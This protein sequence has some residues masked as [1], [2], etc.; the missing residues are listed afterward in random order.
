MIHSPPMKNAV[1][2]ERRYGLTRRLTRWGYDVTLNLPR[3]RKADNV[4][5]R[6]I[7]VIGSGRS[8]NTLVRRVLLASGQVYVPPET[9]VL[10]DILET[11][12]RGTGL[13]WQHRVWL[14]CGHFERH[15]HFAT[16]GID[17]L[18]DFAAEAVEL[19]RSR[20]NIRSLINLFYLHLARHAG[21]NAQRWGE[22]SPWNVYHLPAIGWHYPDACYL[23]LVR[24]G[25]DAA[26]SYLE[27]QL[28]PDLATSARRWTEANQ[29]CDRFA[30]RIGRVR[31]QRYED[32]VAHPEREF[33]EIF[34]WAGLQFDAKMLESQTG[35]MGDVEALAHHAN[36]RKP[37]SA[38]SVGR[39]QRGLDT[40]D[41]AALPRDFWAQMERLGYGA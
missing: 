41:L 13:P 25:R 7:F 36:V 28:Y 16:F 15:P 19:P 1:I 2:R 33:A 8:G 21:S 23:W 12:H 27:A 40:D 6:P 39:W 10:G 32:L 34:E 5:G 37:I 24:D 31:R 17:S 14:F 4:A 38:A 22:K 35:P 11:W 29:A 26:L 20:R 9:Y 30:A 3:I 18:N